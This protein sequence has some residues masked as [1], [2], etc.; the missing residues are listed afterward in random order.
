MEKR[1]VHHSQIIFLIILILVILMLV[2]GRQKEDE[3]LI[4]IEEVLEDLDLEES[5]GSGILI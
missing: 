4:E 1:N 2:F 3:E 5:V